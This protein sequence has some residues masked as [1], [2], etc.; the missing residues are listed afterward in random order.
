MGGRGEDS[1]LLKVEG[2]H[3]YYGD[4]HILQGVSLSVNGGSVVALLGRNG[5]GKST[6][7]YSVAGLVS[8]RRGLVEFEGEN[9]MSLPAYKISQKGIS[10][11][12]QGRRIFS[13]LTVDENLILTGRGSKKTFQYLEE[14]Y[15]FFPQLE[16]RKSHRGNQLSG[17]EQQM[18]AIGR[19]MMSKPKLML[20]DEPSEGLAP[21]LVSE[22][23]SKMG[24]FKEQGLTIFLVEQNRE[25]ALNLAD[26]VYIMVKGSI[27]WESEPKVL[28]AKK[29]IQA[30]YLGVG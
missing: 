28:E 10:I 7:V 25:K 23:Y 9:I 14:V 16:K 12:P 8:F 3:S 21:G 4:S 19:A 22:I 11:V 30:M 18:L 20:L 26:Y 15:A 5:V 24:Q 2:L 13:S 6:F 27:V 1:P 17:G 29:E